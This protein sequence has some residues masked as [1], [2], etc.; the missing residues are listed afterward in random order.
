MEERKL[1]EKESLELITQMIQNSKAPKTVAVNEAFYF[2]T[3]N[4]ESIVHNSGNPKTIRD[5]HIGINSIYEIYKQ[6]HLREEL[7]F[8]IKTFIPN[9]LN[10]Q[11]ARCRHASKEVRPLMY[12]SYRS[13]HYR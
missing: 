1:N 10:Q 4:E 6:P 11:L 9:I 13:Q 12:I 5:Y 3:I 2:Y 8:L 7:E